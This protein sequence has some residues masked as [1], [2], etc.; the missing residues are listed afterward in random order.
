MSAVADVTVFL[1]LVGAAAGTLVSGVSVEKPAATTSP[2][3]DHASTLATSTASVEYDLLVPPSEY[4]RPPDHATRRQRTSHG[5]VAGLLGEAAMSGVTVDGERVSS[6]G[7]DF[8]S[9]VAAVTRDRLHSRGHRTSVCVTWTPYPGAPVRG[10]YRV[11]DRPP[12]TVDVRAATVTVPSGM[13]NVSEPAREAADTG[14]YDGVSTVVARSVVD[15]L[16]PPAQSRYA[17]RG[18]YP[19]AVLMAAR[20]ERMAG[21][22]GTSVAVERQSTVEMNR[23]LTPALATR[24]RTDMR[25]RYDSPADAARAVRVSRVRVTVRT[26]SP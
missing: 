1:L 19:S 6:A 14:G 25:S 26:W 24:L 22:T 5:T 20:Y 11:G 2:A 4:G 9:R 17:L 8:E 15:G 21:L 23:D 3:A 18:D 16:F 12:D 13:E 7:T 10:E